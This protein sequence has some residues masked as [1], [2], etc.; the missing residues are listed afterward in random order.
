MSHRIVPV[1][2]AA[3]TLALAACSG[4]KPSTEAK[5]PGPAAAEATPS[6]EAKPASV[7]DPAVK[8]IEGDDPS[9]ERFSLTITPPDA[10]AVGAEGTVKI[11]IVPKAPWHMNLDYPTSLAVNA[12]KDVTVPKAE[13]RKDDAVR[14]DENQ[15]EFGV[16]FTA[17]VAGDK[18]F[19][20]QV[21]FAV[22]QDDACAPVTEE[23]QFKVA[24]K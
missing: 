21:K 10:A 24:V 14:L 23:I 19:T 1:L 17:A 15:A 5:T 6:A 16:A 18:A 9:Q 20:G 12:P 4:D 22:C 2:S 8:K 7:G 11:T 3:L 13:Q